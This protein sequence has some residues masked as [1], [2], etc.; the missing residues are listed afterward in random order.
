MVQQETKSNL[1]NNAKIETTEPARVSTFLTQF[2]KPGNVALMPDAA[3][4][5]ITKSVSATPRHGQKREDASSVIKI[6]GQA[7]IETPE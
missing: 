4:A 1:P 2:E 7:I 3:S 6:D 5:S